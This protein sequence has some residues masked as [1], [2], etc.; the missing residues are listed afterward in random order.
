MTLD[1][2]SDSM[3]DYA[4]TNNLMR[5]DEKRR[6]LIGSYFADRILLT[7]ELVKWYLEH[8]AVI[9]AVHCV[10]QYRPHSVFKEFER[11]I[12]EARKD[13][14][15]DPSLLLKAKTMKL[16][17][18][19]FYGEYSTTFCQIVNVFVDPSSRVAVPQE[20]APWTS[21]GTTKSPS[22]IAMRQPS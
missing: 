16:I 8:D 13:A 2:A 18:N 15:L 21:R 7:T 22:S 9:T 14:S 6:C 17:G 4:V 19:A 10:L 20:N 3:R 11:Q 5:S 1:D 12:V